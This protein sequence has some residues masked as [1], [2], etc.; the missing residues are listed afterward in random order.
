MQIEA[1]QIAKP[2]SKFGEFRRPQLKSASTD[3]CSE[4]KVES[5]NKRARRSPTGSAQ[6]S[7]GNPSG[8]TSNSGN[9]DNIKLGSGNPSSSG[10]V[11]V[12]DIDSTDLIVEEEPAVYAPPMLDV[13]ALFNKM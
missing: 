11:I 2:H 7:S 8:N 5:V 1:R 3:Y 4:E 6:L 10:N 9:A 13:C 12:D